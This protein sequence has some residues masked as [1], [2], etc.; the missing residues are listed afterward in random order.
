MNEKIKI[1]YL[2]TPD[3]AIKS[4]Q[5]FIE[6]NDYD[7]CA[8][9]TQPQRGQTR[10]KTKEH[11]IIKFAKENNIKIFEP[12]KISKD[13]ELIDILKS[14]DSDF[15]VTFAFGQI[16]SQEVIDIPKF[17]TI[18]LHASLLPKLRGANPIAQSIIEG[19]KYTGITTMK[20]VLEL[21]AGDICLQEK[22]EIPENM[23]V[24]ELMEKIS[25]ISPELLDKTLKGLY[26]GT[27]KTIPQ[28]SADA[29]FTKKLKKEEKI[30]NWDSDNYV[31]HNKIRG[32]YLINTNHTTYNNKIVQIIKTI[33]CSANE[34][35]NGE[36]T[37]IEKTGITVKCKNG[38]LKIIKVKPEGKGEMDAFS[39]A[40]G[41]RIKIGDM[42]I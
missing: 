19:H 24:V 35:K 25:D 10:G 40:N 37:N 12:E 6:S 14:M 22:I 30:I 9:I 38:G 7:V 31:L 33:P 27:L 17:A 3:I 15:F 39:W 42:F 8:L 18:N 16:L 29:T 13:R 34:G 23:N 4:F 41:A 11:N 36:I 1:I 26:E 20:T 2:A 21:D 32:M 28:N 5:F